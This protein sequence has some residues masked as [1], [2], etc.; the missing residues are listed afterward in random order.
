MSWCTVWKGA[1]QDLMDHVR[2]SHRVPEEVQNIK[3]ETLIPPWTVTRQVYMDSLTSRHSGISNDILQFS[4]IGL[5]LT[6]H[7]RVHK[8][9]VPHV[10]F[11]RNYMSQLR[12]LLPLPAVLLTEGRSPDPGNSSVGDSPD[13]VGDTSRPS[14][15][16]RRAFARRRLT[17]VRETPRRIAP[18]LTEQDP[19]S[20][21]GAMVLDCRPQVLPGAI[22]VSGTELAE[23]RSMTRAR[24][25]TAAP[26]ERE[27]S[28]G[29]GGGGGGDLLGSICPELGVAP[30]V[31]PGTDC[32]DELPIP[33][34]PPAYVDQEMESE[35]QK[36]FMDVVSLPTMVT[37]VSDMDGTLCT[38][39]A[40]CLAI[41]PPAVSA[42]VIRPSMATSS[43]G[44]KLL[45]LILSPPS[46]ASVGVSPWPRTSPVVA[47]PED[48]MLFNAAVTNQ[49]QPETSPSL[50]G[51]VACCLLFP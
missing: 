23:I 6:H 25:A 18:R 47:V 11:R 48:L 13:V 4:D 1:P 46:P 12:A 21:A 29:G 7:Y 5:S 28:F 37:P 27:Q 50:M 34:G 38:P 2:G 35:L 44:P 10:A 16:S 32:E 15:P 24:V 33:A 31:D 3:L 26:P 51:N 39:Q 17:R 14:R 43:A 30:L 9:G 45:S 49:I 36:V 41:A 20:A 42:F 22:D 19:L 40:E 8:R